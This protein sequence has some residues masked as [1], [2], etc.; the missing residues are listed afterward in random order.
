MTCRT[1]CRGSPSRRGTFTELQSQKLE[2]QRKLKRQKN[3]AQSPTFE[4]WALSF[5]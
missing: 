5:F 4:I 3:K 2:H 1:C